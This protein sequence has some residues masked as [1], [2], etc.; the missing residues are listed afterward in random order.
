MAETGEMIAV[1]VVEENAE[2]AGLTA[3]L[4]AEVR[5]ACISSAFL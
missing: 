4:E 3:R 5:F 1:K 2:D